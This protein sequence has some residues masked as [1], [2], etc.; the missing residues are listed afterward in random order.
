[1]LRSVKVV[2]KEGKELVKVTIVGTGFV[3]STTAFA[4]LIKGLASEI[5]LIDKDHRKAEGEA[6]DLRHG[7]SLAFPVNVYAGDYEQAAGSDIVIITAGVNQKPG[8]TRIDLVNRNAEIFKK[9]IPKVAQYCAGAVLLVVANPVDILTYIT[10]KLSGFPP[11]KV[12][13]SGTL[14]DS[15]RFRQALSA[16]CGVDARNVHAYIIGEHG[17]TEVPLWSLTNIG[18]VSIEEFCLLSDKGCTRPEK[19]KIFDEVKN[20]GYDII[21]RKEATYY[22]IGLALTR[23]IEAVVRDENSILTVSSLLQGQYGVY[24]VCLSLPSVVNRNGISR[25]LELPLV[26]EERQAFRESAAAMK[27]VLAKVN[28][29]E[30]VVSSYK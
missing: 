23:I 24:D 10:V 15:S 2:K 19:K 12:I 30:A 11:A 13:G 25:V 9:I 22:G 16:H 6:M 3:G 7:T 20:A 4:L 21:S 18:G 1:M 17:D 28:L 27:E 14:L 5:V 26:I 29:G 8:E